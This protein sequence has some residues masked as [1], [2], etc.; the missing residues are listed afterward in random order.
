MHI[1]F[2]LAIAAAVALCAAPVAAQLPVASGRQIAMSNAAWKIFIPDTYVQR[3]GEIADL[4]VHFHGDPQTYWN[5]AKYAKLNSVIVTVNYNGLSSAYQTPFSNASLFQSI[6]NEALTKVRLEAD[7]PDALQWDK[8]GVSSF[9]AGYAAVREILKSPA[10]R[11]DIDALL[12]ADSIHASTSSVDQTPLDSQMADFKTF[13]T[14]AKNESKTF[15][16]SHSQVPTF[17]YEST[18]ETAN[19]LLQYLGLAAPAVNQAGLGTLVYNRHAQSGNFELWG[20]TGSDAAA[21]SKHL[22]YIGDFL[23]DLPLARVPTLSADF[24]NDGPVDALDLATWQGAFAASGA[25]D[26]DADGDS[27]G[28]DFLEWQRQ[29]GSATSAAAAAMATPEPASAGLLVMA[30]AAIAITARRG[31]SRARPFRLRKV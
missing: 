19:E 21:H 14:L 22:Q 10:Y 5:N 12:A 3:P 24:S 18:T 15:I 28:A 25:G 26:S 30:G 13:A 20:A 31:L 16:V 4:L 2:R 27:D 29:L 17:G 1:Y 9:S 8:L 11:N 7:I 6:V 23:N